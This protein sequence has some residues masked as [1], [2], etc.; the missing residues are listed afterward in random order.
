MEIT[1]VI[2]IIYRR[3]PSKK[4]KL[5]SGELFDQFSEF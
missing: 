5:S 4:H 3:P 1:K 2:A